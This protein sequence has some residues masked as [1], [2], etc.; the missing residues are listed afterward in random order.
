MVDSPT[1]T[2]EDEKRTT[3]DPDTDAGGR[4]ADD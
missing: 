2:P 1:R 4:E 3:E